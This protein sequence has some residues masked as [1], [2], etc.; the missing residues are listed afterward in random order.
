MADNPAHDALA[1]VL[2]SET[3]RHFVIE[4]KKYRG[5]IRTGTHGKTAKFWLTYMNNVWHLL[6][7]QRAIKENDLD[8]YLASMRNFCPVLVAADLKN[9]ARYLPIYYYQLRT[10]QQSQP[11]ADVAL[12]QKGFSVARSAVPAC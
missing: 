9:Y 11:G 4:L 1:G 5:E 7:F 2:S 3:F 8:L 6:R 12:R 10:M